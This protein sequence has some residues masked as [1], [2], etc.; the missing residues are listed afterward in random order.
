MNATEG[1][2]KFYEK[3]VVKCEVVNKI[4]ETLCA[5]SYI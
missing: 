1:T 3:V 5:Q 4:T 2:A